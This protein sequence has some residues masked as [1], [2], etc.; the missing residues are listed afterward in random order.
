MTYNLLCA[1]KFIHSA[2]IIHRDL[3]PCNIL[4]N[5][6]FQVQLCD[7]GLARG[8]EQEDVESKRQRR[9]SFTCFT[10]YYRPP[11]VILHYTGYN[12]KADIWS[13]GCIVSEIF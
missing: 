7:F 3:K 6:D 1:V 9:M 5:E 10:R 4:M 13:L 11:E 8:L 12:Q 2:N